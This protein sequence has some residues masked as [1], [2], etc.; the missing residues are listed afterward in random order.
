MEYVFAQLIN[1]LSF[2]AVVY[3]LSCG[4][5]LIQGVMKIVNVAHGSFFMLGGYVGLSVMRWSDSFF[6]AVLAGTVTIA[7]LGL[8]IERVFL[9]WVSSRILHQLLITIGFLLIFRDLVQLIWGG[10]PNSIPVPAFFDE[11]IRLGNIQFSTYRVF[12]FLVATVVAL[13]Q[14]L[15]IE[16]TIL[17]AK[18]R[19]TIDDAQ[20]AGGVGINTALVTA[21]MFTLGAAFTGFGGVMAA[22]FIGVYNTVDIEYLPLAFVVVIIGGEGS[23][24]GAAVASIAVGL[25]D[26]FG[27][28]LFPELAY[29]TL[30]APMALIVALRPQGLFGR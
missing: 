3:L 7:L 23:L 21:S 19:A 9:Q 30:F 29:F 8:A 2:A 11:P 28:A 24:K 20:M 4:L 16:K 10:D 5:S 6:L 14:W 25:I 27:K 18:L 1:A 17:G 12:V 22:P 26:T 15:F 13:G